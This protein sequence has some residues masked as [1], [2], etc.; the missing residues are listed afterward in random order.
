[1][2]LLLKVNIRCISLETNVKATRLHNFMMSCF[3]YSRW[4]LHRGRRYEAVWEPDM[5]AALQLSTKFGEVWTSVQLRPKTK[6]EKG[7]L[8]K[9]RGKKT[10]RLK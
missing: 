9:P 2:M 3:L 5:L 1:M 8:S 10:C 6:H 7:E 4:E